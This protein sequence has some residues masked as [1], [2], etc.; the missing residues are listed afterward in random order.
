MDTTCTPL[1]CPQLAAVPRIIDSLNAEK[2]HRQPGYTKVTT[3]SITFYA[4]VPSS[5]S[6]GRRRP[7]T[8]AFK[9]QRVLCGTAIPIRDGVSEFD[10]LQSATRPVGVDA[11]VS[12]EER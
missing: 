7:T 10:S 3:T 12:H 6:G 2:C 8:A 5:V 11:H 1:V 9:E 4:R